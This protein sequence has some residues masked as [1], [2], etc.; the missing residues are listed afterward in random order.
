[1]TGGRKTGRRTK[2]RIMADRYAEAS[3]S[4]RKRREAR[5][6]DPSTRDDDGL[7]TGLID[8]R[9]DDGDLRSAFVGRMMRTDIYDDIVKP[10]ADGRGAQYD[11]IN[12]QIEDMYGSFVIKGGWSVDKLLT[13]LIVAMRSGKEINR[14]FLSKAGAI[15]DRGDIT[16][17]M[18]KGV[19]E[20][21]FDYVSTDGAGKGER[22]DADTIRR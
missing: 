12:R 15:Y 19:S 5:A 21:D 17:G 16:M 7:F 9:P 1:M 6:D 14:W 8:E 10:Y 20:R 13:I 11:I 22:K 4:A 3:A 2:K 18:L